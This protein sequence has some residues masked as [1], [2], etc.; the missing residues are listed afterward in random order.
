MSEP[1]IQ[2]VWPS[3]GE[4]VSDDELAALY[5]FPGGGTGADGAPA[6]NWTRVNLITSIDGSATHD[7]LSGGLGNS[8]DR[9][10]FDLLRRLC[11]VIVVGAGTIRA[12]GYGAMRLDDGSAAWR[13]A[14]GLT[15][16]PSLVIVS[17]GLDLIPE[18]PIFREAP[19]LP[20]VATA[21]SSSQRMRRRVGEVADVV[22]CGEQRVDTAALFRLLADRGL[23]RIHCEGGPHLFGALIAE[24]SL[25]ELCLTVSPQLEGGAGA[26][27]A[28]GSTPAVP[29]SM[30]LGHVLVSGETLLL[31]YLRA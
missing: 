28:A 11:D 20:I 9:R 5:A 23:G 2:R 15:A 22:I 19:V 8:A 27:I 16:Q 26:R 1:T 18:H 14:H 3:A 21:E 4:P 17:N 29:R 12:E 13:E 10:V 6:G 25:D 24:G 30:R 31:R 7:G